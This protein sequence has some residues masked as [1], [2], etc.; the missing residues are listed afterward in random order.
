MDRNTRQAW[1][2]GCLATEV[3]SAGLLQVPLFRCASPMRPFPMRL[4][5]RNRFLR[6]DSYMTTQRAHEIDRIILTQ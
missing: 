3:P 6:F 5:L 4:S 1:E 2:I